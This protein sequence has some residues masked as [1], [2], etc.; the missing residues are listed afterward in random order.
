MTVEA[1]RV[2]H[3]YALHNRWVGDLLCQFC[4]LCSHLFVPE[5]PTGTPA[6]PVP[7]GVIRRA[8]GDRRVAVSRSVG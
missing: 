6:S 7:V 1:C 3:P 5:A 8:R 4:D 2:L